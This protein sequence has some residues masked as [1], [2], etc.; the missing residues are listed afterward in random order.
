MLFRFY[1]NLP[2]STG[3]V[4]KAFS[5]H[6]QIEQ[7]F[8]NGQITV[9]TTDQG[10]PDYATALSDYLNKIGMDEEDFEDDDELMNIMMHM[11]VRNGD[12]TSYFEATAAFGQQVDNW[13]SVIKGFMIASGIMECDGDECNQEQEG[14]EDV[15][16]SEWMSPY[17]AT[18]IYNAEYDVEEAGCQQA[19]IAQF[20]SRQAAKYGYVVADDN[21]VVA[22]M[23][24]VNMTAGGVAATV[25]AV[26]AVVGLVAYT[27]G[28]SKG[29]A[30]KEA[31]HGYQLEDTAETV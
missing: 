10:L 5:R 17:I 20:G 25:I 30:D 3:D 15:D 9:G 4:V 13:G 14:D 27:I 28:K 24:Y 21:P 1:S 16:F 12:L 19:M 18:E 6:L 8:E 11:A 7:A 23:N 29:S 2:Y 22:A 31:P 26:A